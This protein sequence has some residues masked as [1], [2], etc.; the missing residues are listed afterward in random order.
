M[1]QENADLRLQQEAVE[2]FNKARSSLHGVIVGMDQTIDALFWTLLAEGHALFIGVPG[3]AKTLLISSLSKLLGLEF[4]RIQFT[5]DMMPA[6]L[7]GSE[8]LEEDK[9]TGRR[10]FQFRKGPV[11]CQMLLADEIN[12]TPPKTQSALLQAMQERRVTY[13]GRNYD[14]APPYI[15]FA[16]QNPVE[17]EGTYPLPEAQLDRFLL[18]IPVTYPSEADEREI[19]RRTTSP[20]K[21]ALTPVLS[22]EEIIQY[23]ALVRRIP[24]D[25]KM[26]DLIVRIT[27]SS[28]PSES[29][30]KDLSEVIRYGV[31]PRASQAIALAAKARALLEGRFAVREE[32]V[33]TVAPFVMKHRLV[34]RKLRDQSADQI[35]ERLVNA[36]V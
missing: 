14:L 4:N 21:L 29:M 36:G 13:G 8:I 16:T 1:S 32:D 5:P 19:V 24:L 12:R 34:L 27:R 7:I 31:G 25:D 28:R 6:D 22:A 2:K 18:S 3:L 11:F 23:Q 35:V 26:L 17:S 33:K 15:V 10:E 20:Q 30:P 9:K